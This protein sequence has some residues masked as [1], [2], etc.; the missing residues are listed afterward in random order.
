M[1]VLSL[2]VLLSV[3]TP[4]LAQTRD[5]PR[6][7]ISSGYSHAFAVPSFPDSQNNGVY[8]QL[9]FNLTR[10]LGA[11]AYGRYR[12]EDDGYGFSHSEWSAIPSGRVAF[13]NSSYVVPYG[14]IG[15]GIAR[16]G[17]NDPVGVLRAGGGVDVALNRYRVKHIDEKAISLRIELSRFQYHYAAYNVGNFFQYPAYSVGNFH[18]SA[19]IVI[20]P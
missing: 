4:A 17:S 18:L 14:V 12:K 19:G 9:D 6:I 5:F 15:Y 13:R 1:R 20:V 3:S 16:T 8:A 11:Q 10:W 7:E 2:A